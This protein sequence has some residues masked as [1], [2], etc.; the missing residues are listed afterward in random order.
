MFQHIEAGTK[1]P[2]LSRRHFQVNFL[3]WN[4]WNSIMF[5]LLFVPNV[6]ITDIPALVQMMACRLV[7]TKA[8]SEPMMVSVLTHASHGLNELMKKKSCYSCYS[9]NHYFSVFHFQSTSESKSTHTISLDM[10]S[11]SIHIAHQHTSFHIA[12]FSYNQIIGSWDM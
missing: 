9:K 1:W 11:L 5:S 8:L 7:S 10:V 4:V 12:S 2:P 3:E 6:R